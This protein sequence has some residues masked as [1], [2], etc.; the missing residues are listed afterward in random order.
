MRKLL[1]QELGRKSIKEFHEAQK[2][3]FVVVLDNVRSANNVG[4]IFRTADAF[5]LEGVCLCGITAVPPNPE[6]HKTALGGE[7]T[8][9]WKHFSTTLEAIQELKSEGYT[10]ISIEQTE[11]SILL[12]DF[13]VDCQKKYALVL[14]NEVDG[15][16]QTVIDASHASLEIPQW[17]SKHSLNISVAA[18][19]VLWDMVNKHTRFCL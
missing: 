1:N 4:S 15:V 17:G 8:V 18:G 14:G 10:I 19:I 6:I 16:E 3:P 11:N 13:T 12:P 2:K 7:L 9:A 5:L